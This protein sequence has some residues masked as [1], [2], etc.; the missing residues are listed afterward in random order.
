MPA[1]PSIVWDRA[2]KTYGSVA[3]LEG[4]SLE[5]PAG[6]VL[7]L[8][9]RSGGGKTTALRLVNRLVEPTSG[10]VLVGGRD[11]AS[12]E[13]TALRRG[14]GWVPPRGGLFPHLTL[15]QNVELLPRVVG[16]RRARRRARAREL[17]ALVG[18]DPDRHGPRLAHELSAGE[19]QR[20]GLA[21]A[22]A[23]DPAVLLLDEPT[24]ALDAVTRE[25]LQGE[26]ERLVRELGRTVVL[27]THDL[28]EARRLAARIAVLDAGR[29]H[30]AGTWD[31]LARAPATPFVRELVASTERASPGSRAA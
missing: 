20:G 21:R 8:V 1:P 16:W 27:V 7:A 11:V 31:E 19:Q 4:L 13:L 14:L 3:A 17:L 28:G 18:L 26:L 23:L 30:Q 15:S 5:A 2:R 24:G 29:L 10:R 12:L 22:L 6:R 25:R 9:G